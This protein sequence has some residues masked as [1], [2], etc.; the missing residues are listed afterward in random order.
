MA[1][2]T[3]ATNKPT[4]GQFYRKVTGS[5]DL[6][7]LHQLPSPSSRQRKWQTNDYVVAVA[8]ALAV[9]LALVGAMYLVDAFMRL[10]P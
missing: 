3:D 2:H 10:F 7:H 6:S 8:M 1:T 5:T 9:I 4:T